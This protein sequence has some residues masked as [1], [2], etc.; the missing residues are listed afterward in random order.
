M[1]LS[2][3]YN[4]KISTVKGEKSV[5]LESICIKWEKKN[6]VD[7]IF[8]KTLKWNGINNRKKNDNINYTKII[9]CF[10]N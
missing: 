4:I 3:I 9:F 1:F 8:I 10:F 6:E 2:S 5:K 7:S